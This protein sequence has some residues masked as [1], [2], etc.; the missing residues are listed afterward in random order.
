MNQQHPASRADLE[1]RHGEMSPI[2]DLAITIADACAQ[3]LDG[4]G[5]YVQG[6]F[7]CPQVP[8]D[9]WPFIDVEYE[10]IRDPVAL[11]ESS[12]SETLGRG[13]SSPPPSTQE[14]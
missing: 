4:L 2:L 5:D 14:S 8:L 9:S 10:V 12:I 13:Y 11:L 1:Y 7:F 6:T 3:R